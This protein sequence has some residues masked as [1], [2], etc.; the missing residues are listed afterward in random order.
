M[1]QAIVTKYRGPTNSR[2]SR[3]YVKAQAG[4]KS[5]PY[6]HALSA[7]QNHVT[8]ARA[9]AEYWSWNRFGEMYGGAMPD[10]TGYCFVIPD[11][12]L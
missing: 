4:R 9:F 7:E 10:G 2:G 12:A 8:A 3:I 6:D 5:Y 1:R 11:G